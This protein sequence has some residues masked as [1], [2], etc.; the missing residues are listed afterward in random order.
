MSEYDLRGE[1]V[2]ESEV[3]KDLG[4][5]SVE[6]FRRWQTVMASRVAELEYAL[7][8]SKDEAARFQTTGR[9]MAA[10]LGLAQSYL[11]SRLGD[12]P[13]RLGD[14]LLAIRVV[15]AKDADWGHRLEVTF[16]E[17]FGKKPG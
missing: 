16:P 7:K 11:E 13:P 2:P 6:D 17:I 12:E 3:A 8:Q 10:V 5:A 15:L 1:A 14:L 4:F 9:K